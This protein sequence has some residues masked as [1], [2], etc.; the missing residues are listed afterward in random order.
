VSA[1]VVSHP[2]TV[3]LP[4]PA[5]PELTTEYFDKGNRS[6]KM[7]PISAEYTGGEF[8]S[9]GIAFEDYS[10]MATI[11]HKQSGERRL[12]TP[13]WVLRPDL[14]RQILVNYLERRAGFHKAQPGTDRERLDRANQKL[15]ALCARKES[16][17]RKLC[18]EY[19]D[20]KNTG[21]DPARA[22]KLSE[23][24]ANLDTCLRFERDIAGTV[25]RVVHLF[26]SVCLDSVGVATELG[27]KPTHVRQMLWRLRRCW[28][29][30]NGIPRVIRHRRP[31]AIPT[32]QP[33]SAG[34]WRNPLGLTPHESYSSY[35]EFLG[36]PAMT[37]ELWAALSKSFSP[38][39]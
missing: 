14:L 38:H 34:N 17:L 33:A 18:S 16:V 6:T 35:C 32:T 37:F 9:P 15:A 19:I 39:S 23:L 29:D 20:L 10:R 2:I 12:P 30:M 11:I 13:E 4:G 8:S 3:L 1:A 31:K 28:D 26:Y 27:I 21:I 5:R 25:L 36:I 24:I 22:K 7:M